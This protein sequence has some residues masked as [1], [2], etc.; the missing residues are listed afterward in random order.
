M[1]SAMF[2]GL[3]VTV[4]PDDAVR[5][6]YATN[7]FASGPTIAALAA[8]GRFVVAYYAA[9]VGAVVKRLAPGEL[10]SQ[11]VITLMGKVV[12]QILPNTDPAGH[13]PYVS[14]LAAYLVTPS[15]ASWLA[16][17]RAFDRLIRATEVT[18]QLFSSGGIAT[19]VSVLAA[20]AIAGGGYYLYRKA[21]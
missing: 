20:L 7:Y 5:E 18:P 1:T 21:R 10:P 17:A 13:A 9:D 4:I 15:Q 8:D 19:V 16:L 11:D 14:A 6:F 12:T 2:R 3:G